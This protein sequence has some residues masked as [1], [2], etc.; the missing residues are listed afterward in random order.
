MKY[1]MGLLFAVL[2]NVGGGTVSHA[3]TTESQILIFGKT[4][5]G[6]IKTMSITEKVFR[7]SFGKG[8]N[9]LH[10]KAMTNID[11]FKQVSKEFEL[12]R[13]TVG[14]K[15]ESEFE[16]A[17]ALELGLESVFDLRYQPLPKP[18]VKSSPLVVR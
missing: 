4:K 9:S 12:S 3:Q 18:A 7:Y 11:K 10:R 5:D 16:V 8:L 17:S 13:V 6:Q 2:I 14:L 1:R 15:L